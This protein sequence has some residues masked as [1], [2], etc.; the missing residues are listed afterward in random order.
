M[1]HSDYKKWNVI[2][3]VKE[4]IYENTIFYFDVKNLEW[5][6]VSLVFDFEL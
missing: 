6:M 5:G 3:F 4:V 1:S 2:S